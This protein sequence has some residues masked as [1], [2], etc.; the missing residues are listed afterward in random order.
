MNFAASGTQ[1]ELISS[2]DL[3][4]LVRPTVGDLGTRLQLN[5][6]SL[7]KTDSA[8]QRCT[9]SGAKLGQP[10]GNRSRL[11]WVLCLK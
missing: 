1:L 5:Y 2:P 11:R 3:T 4:R 10:R 6:P 9:F 8:E 7:P